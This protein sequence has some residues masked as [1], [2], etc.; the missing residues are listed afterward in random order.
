MSRAPITERSMFGGYAPPLRL[1]S[2]AE[3]RRWWLG[4]W[5]L[6]VPAVSSLFLLLF[7]TMPLPLP[8]PIFP[9]LGLIAIFVWAT[10]Q[11]SLMP[12]WAAFLIG[13]VADLLFAQPLGVNATLFALIAGFVRWFE[14][15]YGHHAHIFDWALALALVAGFEIGSWLLMD[16]GGQPTALAPLGWQ[17]LTS[18]LAYPAVSAL[19]GRLQ[20]TILA[21]D[22]GR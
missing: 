20:R 8:L 12:P 19:C 21:A 1:M 10:F 16:L 18:L 9:E 17:W 7:M 14:V 13:L 3:R 15:R 4:H 2:G 22:G 11:P 6:A 5:R